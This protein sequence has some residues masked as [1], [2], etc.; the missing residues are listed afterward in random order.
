MKCVRI[1]TTKITVTCSVSGPE[2]VDANRSKLPRVLLKRSRTCCRPG[3]SQ[4]P[5]EGTGTRNCTVHMC[6][7]SG[8]HQIRSWTFTYMH[9][10]C[11]ANR[12][13]CT[14]LCI[15]NIT[16]LMARCPEVLNLFSLAPQVSSLPSHPANQPFYPSPLSHRN[17]PPPL[18]TTLFTGW[19]STAARRDAAACGTPASIRRLLQHRNQC[20]GRLEDTDADY[21]CLTPFRPQI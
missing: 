14:V 10:P 17:A 2:P 6:N 7:G 16:V 21:T 15:H 20:E 18:S 4:L 19:C 9:S 5:E 8:V 13:A 3:P 12:C 1:R 11:L